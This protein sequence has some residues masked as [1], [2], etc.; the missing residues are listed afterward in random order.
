MHAIEAALRKSERP[1]TD[2]RQTRATDAA[3]N[4]PA[5]EAGA[6]RGGTWSTDH[7][8][9]GHNPRNHVCRL[10]T[11]QRRIDRTRTDQ[12][13]GERTSHIYAEAARK[14]HVMEAILTWVAPLGWH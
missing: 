8:D 13:S 10:P 3:H 14:V 12:S 5:Q 1:A 7:R 4:S 2:V 6:S 9:G 11:R